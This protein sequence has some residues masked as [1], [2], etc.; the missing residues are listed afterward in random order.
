MRG[1][2][3]PRAP[4][5]EE[6]PLD[7][8]GGDTETDGLTFTEEANAVH[9]AAADLIDR[10]GSLAELQRGRLTAAKREALAACPEALRDAAQ[11]IEAALDKTDPAQR[12][13]LADEGLDLE[14]QFAERQALLRL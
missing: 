11:A 8:P 6:A 3:V 9:S 7:E 12:A 2:T 4:E 13:E 5:P 10:M 14:V 1:G